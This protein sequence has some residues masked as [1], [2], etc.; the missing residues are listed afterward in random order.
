MSRDDLLNRQAELRREQAAAMIDGHPFA[1]RGELEAIERTLGLSEDVQAEI[2]RRSRAAQEAAA[3]DRRAGTVALVARQ[4][5]EFL[6]EMGASGAAFAAA[7]NHLG[8]ARHLAAQIVAT[9][10]QSGLRVPSP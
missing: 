4:Y 6:D 9:C 5:R 7:M 8:R 2:A 10:Q 3:A 1:G